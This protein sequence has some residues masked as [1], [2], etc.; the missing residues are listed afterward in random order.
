[1]EFSVQNINNTVR[2][3]IK[4]G[5]RYLLGSGEKI[6]F[7]SDTWIGEK[8]LKDKFPRLFSVSIQQGDSISQMGCWDRFFWQWHLRWSRTLFPREEEQKESLL[9]EKKGGNFW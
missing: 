7:W 9:R 3:V 1:M 5:F 6:K 4:G 2:E 8:P